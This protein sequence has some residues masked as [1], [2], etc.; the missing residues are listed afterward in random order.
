M[1]FEAIV[2]GLLVFIALTLQAILRALHFAIKGLQGM[3]ETLD[4][5]AS[6]PAPPASER[7]GGG[8]E[9]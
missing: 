3:S 5:I 4:S 9:G 7:A 2:I 1:S 8:A 6:V